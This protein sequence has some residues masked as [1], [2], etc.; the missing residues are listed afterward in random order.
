VRAAV[1][2]LATVLSISS[3]VSATPRQDLD[4]AHAAFRKGEF[5]VALPLYNVLLYPVPQLAS[6]DDLADAYVGLGVCRLETGDGTGARREFEKALQLDPNKQLDPLLITNKDAIRLFDDTKTDLRTRAEREAA[7]KKE[8]EL[9]AAQQ[10]YYD[11]LRVYESH[12]YA[13]NF[14]PFGIG[15]FQNGQKAKGV[16]FLGSQALTAGASVT[17]FAY[18]VNKY[19][20][21]S[22]QV[23]LEDGPRV[24]RLQQ[25]EIG[26][27]VAFF[28]LYVWSVIDAHLHYVPKK[29]VEGDESLLPDNLKIKPKTA[30]PKKT[31]L[32]ERIHISPMFT[33]DGA[34]IGLGWE[35]D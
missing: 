6:A 22:N 4:R 25:F 8:A 34:G 27:G 35:T 23:P 7:K 14:A 18:L 10:A 3:A 26:T 13:L 32:L 30:K 29:R 16:F 1:I 9:I 15:Q 24:R 12:S 5:S 31:S 11:S 21:R 2:I 33:P 28:G 17:I 20:I 19:G